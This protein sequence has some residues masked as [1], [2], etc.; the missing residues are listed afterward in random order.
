MS[1]D[2]RQGLLVAAYDVAG[3][4]AA[5]KRWAGA[6]AVL[7]PY[8]DTVECEHPCVL[9]VRAKFGHWLGEAERIDEAIV[10]LRSVA[11][12]MERQ[13]GSEHQNTLEVRSNLA[14]WLSIADPPR[15]DEAVAIARDVVAVRTRILGADD[16][17]T[18]YARG[19]L[20]GLLGQ[21]G[22][23]GQCI[24][25]LSDLLADQ[26]RILGPDHADA[27]EIRLALA[28]WL[29]KVA[30]YREAFDYARHNVS[31]THRILG[32]DD[33][34]TLRSRLTFAELL[35]Q[36]GRVDEAIA[37]LEDLAEDQGRTSAPSTPTPGPSST[38][39]A[40]GCTRLGAATRPST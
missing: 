27:L 23:V 3:E 19:N 40:T 18:F 33:R 1:D 38:P 2:D 36:T 6:V 34:R 31:E 5:A 10:V 7:A 16:R 21:L 35:G 39:S 4:L 14:Y 13:L 20:A 22:L 17:G 30:R 9:F 29:E 32:A 8:L 12:A 25:M 28:G 37:A 11:E 26:Q 15:A 24:D